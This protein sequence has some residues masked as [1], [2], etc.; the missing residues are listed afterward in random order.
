MA[1]ARAL[2]WRND[3][4]QQVMFIAPTCLFLALL[5]LY[6]F[7]YSVFLSLHRVRLTNLQRKVFV[8][9][10]NYVALLS[11]GLFLRSLQNTVLLTVAAIA[12]EVLLGFIVAKIFHELAGRRV[13]GVARS[14][15][16]L[17]MMV[18]PLIVG[19]IFAYIFNPAL[20]VAN[21]ILGLIGLEG[22]PWFADPTAARLTI[23]L[24]TVWQWTPFMMLLILAA[25]TGVRAD[26]YE[27]ARMDGASWWHILRYIEIPSVRSVVL[28][29]VTLRIID[30]LRFFDVIYVTTR[31]GPG[32]ATMVL[33]L[34]TYQQDFQYFQA[35][36]GSAAAVLILA[37]S[38]LVTTF[39]V[40]LLRRDEP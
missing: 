40:R 25:L 23:L 18:T 13:A 4:F 8:G 1:P 15:F 2:P 7:V 17:P 12:I 34:F 10:D 6:P 22:V 30:M 32:D 26:L 19:M 36:T 11:D 16:L 9:F 39:T 28:L 37:L 5:T 38:I 29:G 24:I 33:T 31:G 3:R 20:G 35:G 21:Q 14:L 27:A